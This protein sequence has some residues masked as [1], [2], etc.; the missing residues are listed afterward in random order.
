VLN[1]II[2]AQPRVV[3]ALLA[4]LDRAEESKDKSL[5]QRNSSEEDAIQLNVSRDELRRIIVCVRHDAATGPLCAEAEML[6]F[7]DKLGSAL[8]DKPFADKLGSALGD[9]PL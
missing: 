7:A 2:A 6:A 1:Y 3:L 8:G 4:A 9:K 5:L